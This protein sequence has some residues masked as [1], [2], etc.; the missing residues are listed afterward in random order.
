MDVNLVILGA[1]FTGLAIARHLR[2]S[3]IAM[4]GTTRSRERFEELEAAGLEP[5]LLDGVP[6]EDLRARLTEATHLIH[7]IAPSRE[8]VEGERAVDPVLAALDSPFRDLVPELQWL[9]YLSTVGVYGDHGGAWVDE[10]T[11]PNPVSMRSKRRLA[12]ENEW[13][14]WGGATG[15]P[16]AVLRLSGI[17]GRGRNAFVKVDD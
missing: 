13:L 4:A 6:E 14:D 8:P 11:A 7:S 16:V 5:F 12:A 10:D 2:A 1:G 9:G 15:V 17:Y 3:G